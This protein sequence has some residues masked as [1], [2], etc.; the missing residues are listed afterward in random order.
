MIQRF[1]KEDVDIC[2]GVS[3]LKEEEDLSI[4]TQSKFQKNNDYGNGD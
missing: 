1:D 2:I 4:T 3:L